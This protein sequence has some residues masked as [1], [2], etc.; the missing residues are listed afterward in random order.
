MSELLP[1]P[2]V[3]GPTTVMRDSHYLNLVFD[4]QV[5]HGVWE[6]L[7]N[8]APLAVTPKRAEPRMPHQQ[9][10][11]MLELGKQRLRERRTCSLLI[12]FGRIPKVGFRLGME[13]IPH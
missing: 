12:E 1:S 2:P 8:E 13:R 11:G 7:H 3:A 4:K 6:M 10:H 9:L 5:N